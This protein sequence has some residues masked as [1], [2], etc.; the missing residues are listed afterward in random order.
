VGQ[1][2]GPSPKWWVIWTWPAQ[3]ISAWASTQELGPEPGR[4]TPMRVVPVHRRASH[5]EAPK[6]CV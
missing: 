5:P 4:I 6:S 1:K 3:S 2:S